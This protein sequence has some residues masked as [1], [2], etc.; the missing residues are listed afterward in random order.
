MARPHALAVEA[1]A[2]AVPEREGIEAD[3]AVE[4]TVGA[5]QGLLGEAATARRSSA[6]PVVFGRRTPAPG[7]GLLASIEQEELQ[8]VAELGPELLDNA[9]VEEEP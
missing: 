3:P 8:P 4:P 1:V 9:R 5:A 6:A 2:Q 7:I